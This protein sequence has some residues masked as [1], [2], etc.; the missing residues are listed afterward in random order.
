MLHCF[1]QVPFYSFYFGFGLYIECA[2]QI[3]GHVA[4]ICKRET[5]KSWLDVAGTYMVFSKDLAFWLRSIQ[6]LVSTVRSLFLGWS[7]SSEESFPL[8]QK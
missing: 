7:I 6:M 4:S 3:S 2:P 1:L 5:L 8:L